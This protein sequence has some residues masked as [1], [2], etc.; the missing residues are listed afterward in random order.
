M[1]GVA[2]SVALAVVLVFAAA[3]AAPAA[4]NG[5]VGRGMT[6]AQLESRLLTVGDLPPGWAVTRRSTTGQ[7]AVMHTGCLASARFKSTPHSVNVTVTFVQSTGLPVLSESLGTARHVQRVWHRV[8]HLL[9]RC[10]SVTLTTKGTEHII[11]IA[12]LPFPR[13]ARKTA[14]FALSFTVQG[15]KAGADLVLFDLGR[16]AGVLM[17]V[18]L[19]SPP[20][21]VVEVLVR[22]A[23]AKAR[24][25]HVLTSERARGG[26]GVRLPRPSVP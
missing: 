4:A 1:R 25:S 13:V 15:I 7:S 2:A 9:G 16:F 19:G 5:G 8:T 10:R 6:K 3:P 12:P 22:E 26:A 23:V 11:S 17:F 18:Y 24:S 14:A 20:A 21:R